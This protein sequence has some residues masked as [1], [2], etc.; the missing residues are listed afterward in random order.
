MA[1]EQ[2]KTPTVTAESTE[3]TPEQLLVME[4]SLPTPTK[5]L[6]VSTNE[7][8]IQ[9][10]AVKTERGCSGKKRMCRQIEV[11]QTDRGC[12]DR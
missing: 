12:K 6:P 2:K 3:P 4:F 8:V 11:V 9:I 10:E 7:T 1:K 5:Y